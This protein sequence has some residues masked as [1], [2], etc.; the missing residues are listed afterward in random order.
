MK[1]LYIIL[2]STRQ[3]RQG[4]KVAQWVKGL[5][6][7]HTEFETELLDLRDYPMP[8]FDLPTSPAM[9]GVA[10]DPIVI[11]WTA[12][13]AE[14]DAFLIVTPEYNHG[15]PAVL[16]NALDHVFKEWNNKPV[17]IVSYGWSASGARSASQL[18]DVVTELKMIPI[19]EQVNIPFGQIMNEKGELVFPD[20]L[21]KKVEGTLAE[22]ARWMGIT[23]QAR[24]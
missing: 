3:G 2:G 4:E 10:T 19:R 9:G 20:Y 14:G 13:I 17:A 12:K 11:K 6:S 7:T 16:K 24:K 8:F 5:T 23:E 18:I 21:A 22:V 1:K 15:Y